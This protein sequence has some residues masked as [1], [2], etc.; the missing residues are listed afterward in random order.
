MMLVNC[1]YIVP[2][3]RLEAIF[4]DFLLHDHIAAVLMEADAK[5]VFRPHSTKKEQPVSTGPLGATVN[6]RSLGFQEFIAK[7]HHARDM[8]TERYGPEKRHA[9]YVHIAHMSH[10]EMTRRYGRAELLKDI[11][12]KIHDIAGLNHDNVRVRI[13]V[14]H[15]SPLGEDETGM[16]RV[17]IKLGFRKICLDD[18]LWRNQGAVV[19]NEYFKREARLLESY[20]PKRVRQ[21]GFFVVRGQQNGCFHIP[22]ILSRNSSA[23]QIPQV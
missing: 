8:P 9:G 13:H 7:V 20:G 16:V 14:R 23:W 19:C 5:R 4:L 15:A 22:M 21:A 6:I 12:R 11:F 3:Y 1:E 10:G 2:E 18:L 17:T